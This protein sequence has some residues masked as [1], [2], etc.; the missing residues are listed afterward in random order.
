[1]LVLLTVALLTTAPA[2][3]SPQP[4]SACS[5]RV[6]TADLDAALALAESAYADADLPALEAATAH[7]AELLPCVDAIVSRELAARYHRVAGLQAFVEGQED[8]AERA[9]AAAR[10]IDPS[11]RFPP[12]LVPPGNPVLDHYR[13]IPVDAPKTLPVPAPAEARIYFDGVE[14]LQR[15]LSWPSVVQLA[16]DDG[17]VIATAWVEAN[18]ELPAYRPE[19]VAVAAPP[20]DLPAT[21]DAATDLA[22]TPSPSPGPSAMS[23]KWPWVAGSAAMAVTTGALFAASRSAA[24]TYYDPQTTGEEELSTLRSRANGLLFASAGTAAATVGLGVVAIVF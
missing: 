7:A 14:T 23:R 20:S 9:F 3:A 15:P 4:A 24:S 6:T 16:E 13:A 18:G 21:A 22:A 11:Y 17:T 2:A 19:G 8:A 12:E 5:A 10:A 1:M